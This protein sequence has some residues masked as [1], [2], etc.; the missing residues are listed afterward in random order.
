MLLQAQA[1]LHLRLGPTRAPHTTAAMRSPSASSTCRRRPLR[2]IPAR[3]LPLA[4]LLLLDMAS[5][6]PAGPH[7]VFVYGTLMAEEVARLLLGRAPPAS[8]ALL[9]DHRR[10]SIRGRVYPAILP[11]PGGAVHGKV[12]RG[13]TDEELHVFDKFEDEE[14]ARKTVEVSLAD[15]SEKL[16][17]FAYIWG[18]ESD[19]N[20]YGEWDF[21]EWRKVHLKDYLEMTREF[22]EELE[23]SEPK[24]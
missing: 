20:L 18:N 16:L 10:F 4:R 7:S 5:P 3:L 22:M 24:P 11:V 12:F 6:A 23:Q 8:P 15:S 9:P 21:E 13:I 1:I 2:L 19:P 14:Y 17:V